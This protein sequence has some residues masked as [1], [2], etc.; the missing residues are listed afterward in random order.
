MVAA[1]WTKS[2]VRALA[3]NIGFNSDKSIEF[4]SIEDIVTLLNSVGLS[5]PPEPPA[6]KPRLRFSPL[7]NG[8]MELDV[9]GDWVTFDF[10]QDT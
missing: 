3:K 1:V 5:K 7:P 4:L 2:D 8:H 6:R 9:D 10:N